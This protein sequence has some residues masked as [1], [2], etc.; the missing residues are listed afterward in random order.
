VAGSLIPAPIVPAPQPL[1]RRYGLFTA[2]SGPLDLPDHGEGGGVR[3]TPED[4]GEVAAYGVACYGSGVGQTEAPAKPLDGVSDE[5]NTGVFVALATIECNAVGYTRDEQMTRLRRRHEAGEQAAVE[6]AL[7]SGLDFEGNDL[8]IRS[9]DAEAV[10]IPAGF[11]PGLITDVIGGLERYAYTINGYGY[12]AFI[13]APVEVASFAHE[14][15]QV[16]KDGPR[17]VTP[18]GSIWSFG[19]YPGGSIIITGQTTVWRA[20]GVDVAD[21]FNPTTNVRLLAAERAYAVS[22]DCFAGRAT[23]DPLE[24]TSP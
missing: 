8:G 22:F 24:L 2:A 7:W 11:D 21:A 9:L 20:S 10:D 17:L 15:G 19:A 12:Q 3:Y 6:R 4:C 14:S 5:V 18:M 23:F 13:H 1:A 16:L